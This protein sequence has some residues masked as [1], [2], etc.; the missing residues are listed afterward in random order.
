MDLSQVKLNKT[1]WDSIEIPVN[2]KEKDILK[3]IIDGYDDI[4]IRRNSNQSM[5]SYLRMTSISNIDDYI[6]KEYFEQ[7]VSEIDS[8]LV[9]NVSTKK[10]KKVDLMRLNLNKVENLH[11]YGVFESKLLDLAKSIVTS[12]HKNKPF[13]VSYFTLYKFITLTVP[14]VN[15]YVNDCVL[16]ILQKYESKVTLRQLVLDAPNVLEKNHELT[17]N[18]DITL[19]SHQKDIFRAL[20]NPEYKDNSENYLRIKEIMESYTASDDEDEDT[21]DGQQEEIEQA[22]A[23]LVDLNTPKKSTLVLYSAPTGTGKTLTPLALTSNYRVIFVCAARH[24]GLALAKNAITMGRK[25]AFAFGCETASDVRLHY[26]AASVYTTN[27]RT[28]KISKVDNSVGDKVE[29]MICDIKS[30][31]CAMHY[32]TAFNPVPNLLMYWD[33]PTISLDYESHPLHEHIHKMWKENVVPNIVLSSATLPPENEI[34]ETIGDFMGKFPNTNVVSIK[35]HDA[36]KS[37]PII[38]KNGYNVTP[39]F[40]TNSEDY[41]VA[42]NAAN[43]CSSNKTLLRYID[44]S[45]CVNFI[46]L[47]E[48]NN[49]ITQRFQIERHF[50]ELDDISAIKIKEHYL[51]L[52]KN[53][54]PGLWGAIL[55]TLRMTRK[56]VLT[57]NASVDTK[58]NRIR[59][60]K[61]IGPGTTT[62]SSTDLPLHP[63]AV[64]NAGEPISKQ[65]SI[66]FPVDDLPK[67]PADKNVSDPP[68]VFITTKDAETLTGGPTI[69]IA[70]DVEKIAKFY[71]KQSFIPA[72]VIQTIM[73]KIEHNNKLSVRISELEA[74]VEDMTSSSESKDKGSNYGSSSGSGG[75]KS[76]GGRNLK[77]QQKTTTADQ[78]DRL[79]TTSS[80]L[81]SLQDQLSATYRMIKPA[82]LNEV[83]IPNKNAH[84]DR[85]ASNPDTTNAFTSNI[86][87]DVVCEIMAIEG[88][89]DTWKVLLLMGIGVFTNHTS[90]SY[91]E[92]MKRM[93]SEQRLYLIIASSDYIYGTNYQFSHGYLGKDIVLTQQKMLQALGRI[94]RHNGKDAYSVRLRDNKQGDI[95]FQPSSN[96]VE[97]RNMNMLFSSVSTSS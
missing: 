51:F 94:G 8:T 14:H 35:S 26:S 13:H 23:A 25:V 15:K 67:P 3:M 85:W 24:V 11:K 70:E 62:S 10:L 96:N 69:F 58:G 20:R 73:E 92:V 66:R 48:E 21:F 32:M 60:V 17:S 44:L 84:I 77:K 33:E 87:N 12:A 22:T 7:T 63:K 79:E 59:K 97:S 16:S 41:E 43:H 57:V 93:A 75:K 38:D 65:S 36:K 83:F 53:V 54:A 56:Q 95:L 18:Q 6:Y 40:V 55:S 78:D 37:I 82:E 46:A 1:E 71:M 27:P 86:S 52:L 74:K 50:T 76:D 64:L 28:G 30:Y 39:H 81:K 4:N 61:S 2:D 68:G 90:Q 91:T 5:A 9:C 80:S 29:I 49:Y 19:Y 34:G 47:L 31:L 89:N 45:E 42:L 88:V 72:S